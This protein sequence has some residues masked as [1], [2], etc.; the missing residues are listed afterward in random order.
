MTGAADPLILAVVYSDGHVA[1]RYLADLGYRLRDGGVAVAGIVQHNQFVRDRAK[2]D[3][4]IEE[5][6]SGVVIRVS[7]NRG[8]AARGCRLDHGALP[9]ACALLETALAHDPALLIVNKFGKMESEGRG[10]REALAQAVSRGVPML[11]GVPFR[12]IEPWRCF[13]GG[14]A[15]ECEVGSTQ[16][17]QWLARKGFGIAPSVGATPRGPEASRVEI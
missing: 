13:A 4:D 8:P 9:Q 12:N 17:T 14:F 1:D 16:V 5:L 7:E 11:I 6:A 15:E 3:M 2:C 10:T